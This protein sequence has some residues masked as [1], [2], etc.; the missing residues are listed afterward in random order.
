M[1]KRW[2]SD[3]IVVGDFAVPLCI[4]Y[5]TKCVIHSE[6]QHLNYLMFSSLT[7]HILGEGREYRNH[8]MVEQ[9]GGNRTGKD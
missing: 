9:S 5:E 3:D 1:I 7:N 6:F 4:S 2:I 8:E